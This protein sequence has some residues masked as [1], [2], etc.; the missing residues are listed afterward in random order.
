MIKLNSSNNS[1][2]IF[3]SNTTGNP[4]YSIPMESAADFRIENNIKISEPIIHLSENE[5]ISIKSLY[6]LAVEIKKN[7]PNNNQI[8][9]LKTFEY[10]EEIR[11]RMT[12]SNL[13]ESVNPVQKSFKDQLNEEVDFGQTNGILF[14]KQA[15]QDAYEGCSSYNLI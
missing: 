2:E 3:E 12:S 7:N 8:D 9:W 6:E 11:L 10:L 14:T 5:H 4:D 13:L 15:K 1:I